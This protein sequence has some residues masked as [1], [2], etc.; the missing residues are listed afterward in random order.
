MR[1]EEIVA[2]LERAFLSE[3]RNLT[4]R[5]TIATLLDKGLLNQR[6]VE[7]VVACRSVERLCAAGMGRCFAMAEVAERLC[8]SY[9]KI[10]AFI[11][12]KTVKNYAIRD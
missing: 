1:K 5:Q 11:Y 4:P 2:E 10:R 3:Q 9:E 6:E 8:C 7:R 12:Q